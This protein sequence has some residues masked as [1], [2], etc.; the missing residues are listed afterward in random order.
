MTDHKPIPVAGYT[1]QSE[2]NVALVNQ[3][4]MLEERI[5]R[6]LDAMRDHPEVD[7]RWLAIGRTQIE[8]GFMAV[9]RSVFKPKRFKGDVK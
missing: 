3:N 1:D 7:Q 6:Q 4:K 8:Q 2:A 9:N 5:L